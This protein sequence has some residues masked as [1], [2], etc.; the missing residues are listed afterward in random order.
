MGNDLA[1]FVEQLPS[2]QIG[3]DLDFESIARSSDF[4][5]RLQ[6]YTKGKAVNKKLV[7]PGNYGIP[8]SD[9]EVTDLGDTI[10]VLP[11]ARRPK[12]IDLK[13]TE[14]VVAVYDVN[15]A[16]FK[17]IQAQSAEKESGCMYGPSFLVYERSTGQFLEFFCGTK[18]ARMEAKRIFAFLP[19]TRA[20]IDALE[21]TGVDTSGMEPHGP[22][23][24]TLKSKLIEKGQ[25]SWHVPV[26]VKC[27]APFTK[28]PLATVIVE[29]ITKFL[30]VKREGAAVSTGALNN[31]QDPDGRIR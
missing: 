26:A 2:T 27:S 5:P 14:N 13:D 10:D 18:S 12:A 22:L 16:E 19:L 30:D 4:L 8:V 28:L 9:D 15:D 31:P 23:P 11:L 7:Q 3:S 29:Q 6:L 17:R 1:F 25:W 24:V 20:M 21:A